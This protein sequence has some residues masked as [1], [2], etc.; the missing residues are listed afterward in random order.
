MRRNDEAGMFVDPNVDSIFKGLHIML[1]D[2]N[3]LSFYS[4]NA[5]KAIME[6][7]LLKDQ[8]KKY[9][10]MYEQIIKDKQHV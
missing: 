2:E 9:E 10:Q 5:K 4:N 6:K 1:D 8:V 7:F 3:K